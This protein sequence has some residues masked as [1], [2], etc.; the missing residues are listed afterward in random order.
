MYLNHLIYASIIFI[1][2]FDFVSN[3]FRWMKL[4]TKETPK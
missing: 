4:K 1:E 2:Y 3:P